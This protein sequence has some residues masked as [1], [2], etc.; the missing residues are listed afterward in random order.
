MIVKIARIAAWILVLAIVVLT[1]GPPMV[2]PVPGFNRDLE[3]VSA[4]ALLGLAFGLA[5][6]DRRMMLALIGIAIAAL[7]EALQQVV[8]GR[9]AYFSDFLINAVGACAGL[10]MA[11]LL[12]WFRCRTPALGVKNDVTRISRDGS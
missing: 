11:I 4:F 9:H 6:P 2:R 7:M 8:P 1:L 5:Y 10:A 3:H 12:D